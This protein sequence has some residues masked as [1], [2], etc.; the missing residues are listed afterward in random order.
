[1]NKQAIKTINLARGPLAAPF[2]KVWRQQPR[3]ALNLKMMKFLI[4]LSLVLTG[5]IFLVPQQKNIEGT[6][7]LD[8]EGKKCEVTIVRIQMREGYFTGTLDIPEQEVFDKPVSVKVDKDSV[9]IIFDDQG[10]CYINAAIKN[11]LLAG[12][13]VVSGEATPVRFYRVATAK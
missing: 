8:T 5:G 6:W 11:S 10:A 1:M 12:T 4:L 2:V 3:Q 9:K 13:S 7:I